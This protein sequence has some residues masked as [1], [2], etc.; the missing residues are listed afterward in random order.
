MAQGTVGNR[1]SEDERKK[2]DCSASQHSVAQPGR[3]QF[4]EERRRGRRGGRVERAPLIAHSFL[5]LFTVSS[6]KYL[7]PLVATTS[8]I[9]EDEEH[10]SSLQP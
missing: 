1:A 5:S 9:Y 7:D 6:S 4:E 8:G 3:Q 2:F 10:S